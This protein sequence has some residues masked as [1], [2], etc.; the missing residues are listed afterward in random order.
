MED[1]L[2]SLS[3]SIRRQ[4]IRILQSNKEMRLMQ[5][6]RELEVKDHTKVIFHLKTLKESKIIEQT[7]EKSYFL[8]LEGQ[9]ILECLILLEKYFDDNASPVW[10]KIQ[11]T[12]FLYKVDRFSLVPLKK[13][14]RIYAWPKKLWILI[15]SDVDGLFPQHK[16]HP[17][18]RI[19]I[20][21]TANGWIIVR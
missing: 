8:T 7:S 12:L 3:N 18:K 4:I 20:F 14:S 6:V 10:C 11:F 9:K 17:E 19:F 2:S 21:A 5:I 13:W 15:R 1:T 16:N